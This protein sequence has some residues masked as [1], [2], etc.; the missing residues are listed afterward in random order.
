MNRLCWIL[1]TALC[2]FGCEA[3][4]SHTNRPNIIVIIGDDHGYP[5]FGFMGDEIVSTPHLDRLASEGTLFSR[6]YTSAS[7]C[8]DSLLTLLTGLHPEQWYAKIKILAEQTDTKRKLFEE[9]LDFETMPRILVRNGYVAFQGGKYW[10]GT[11]DRAGF[12]HGTKYRVDAAA[13]EKFGPVAAK[14]GADGLSLGRETLAPLWDFL[15]EFKHKKPFY[16]WFAPM[17]PHKPH[18]A[19]ANFLALYNNRGLSKTA[20]AYYANISRFDDVVGQLMEYLEANDLRE[21]TLLIYIADNGWEQGPRMDTGNNGGTHGKDSIYDLGFRTP[22]IFSWPGVIDQGLVYND[23]VA[24]VD[25]FPTVLDFLGLQAPEGRMG[26]SLYAK[27]T[28]Q[29]TFGRSDVV[30]GVRMVRRA[31]VV[32]NNGSVFDWSKPETA[33][34]VRDQDWRFIWR[35]TSKRVE[36]YEIEKDP[37]ETNDRAAQH[38]DLVEKYKARID[39]WVQECHRLVQAPE[40][41]H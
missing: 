27:L 25:V 34:F 22:L 8:R 29:D 41:S 23:L 33:Y 7:K 38:P 15:D 1:L 20:V 24:E 4:P 21:D 36:L 10:E 16:I 19:P 2:L 37:G 11:Y 3:A 32:R 12:S 30:G 40:A 5:Y 9:I 17:L 6:A 31:Q 13:I 35:K 26:V 14:A 18:N 39:D 28:R